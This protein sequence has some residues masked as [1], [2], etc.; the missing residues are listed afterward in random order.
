MVLYVVRSSRWR[1]VVAGRAAEFEW[2]PKLMRVDD[3]LESAHLGVTLIADV[4]G[5]CPE[6]V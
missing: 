2:H 4:W 6:I 1:G 5:F 3:F